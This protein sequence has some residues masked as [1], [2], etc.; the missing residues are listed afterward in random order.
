MIPE[1]SPADLAFDAVVGA[2]GPSPRDYLDPVPVGAQ[3][4][5]IRFAPTAADAVV[6]AAVHP[7]DGP[8]KVRDLL[9]FDVTSEVVD[10]PDAPRHGP[11][12]RQQMLALATSVSAGDAVVVRAGQ[13]LLV[14]AAYAAGPTPGLDRADLVITSLGWD[15]VHIPVSLTT[16]PAPVASVVETSL[17][18]TQLSIVAGDSAQLVLTARWISGP[19]TDISFEKSP[20]FLDAQVT[21]D[22]VS[23]HLDPGEMVEVPLVFR[24]PAVAATGDFDLAVRQFVPGAPANVALRVRI[25]APATTDVE[26]EDASRAIEAF[27][28]RT[29]GVLV[30]GSP[31]GP[32][33]RQDGGFSQPYSSGSIVKPLVGDPGYVRTHLS[34]E[35]AAVRCFGTDDP[36]GDEPYVIA[37]V[38]SIDPAKGEDAV[39]T[40][41]VGPPDHDNSINGE[42]VFFQGRQLANDFTVP[43]DGEVRVHI[44]VWDVEI[45]GKADE[46]KKRAGA[47]A[48]A[49]I[50]AGLV[51]LGG[52]TGAAGAVLS[53][54]AG[55]L[56]SVGDAIGGVVADLFGDDFIG[57]HDFVIDQNFITA[58]RS[59]PPSLDRHSDS[60][61]GVTY[62]FPQLPENDSPIGRSWLLDGGPGRGQYR[63]FLTVRHTD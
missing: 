10:D 53:K 1:F 4:D 29:L 63:V 54:V 13:V 8:V 48:Q 12:P 31:T 36:N 39:T 60:I 14:R 16:V 9:V 33:T 32:V 25:L 20:V 15:A 30:V 28:A 40:T 17:S 55:L 42:S 56:D 58:L 27:W 50:A 46:V 11:R 23:A 18:A 2:E 61:P 37:T 22:P 34:V 38:Y 57:E 24:A 6:Q 62:N 3:L 43:G 5:G 59:A 21:M 44:Q 51:A 52:A 41:Q 19:G 26:L 49:A 35:I 7:I 45:L 47:A